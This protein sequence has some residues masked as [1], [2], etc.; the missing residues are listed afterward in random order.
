MGG[1]RNGS[2]GGGGM[3]GGM[4]RRWDSAG[5][6]G[7]ND[8]KRPYQPSTNFNGA[9]NGSVGGYAPKPAYRSYDQ[10]KPPMTS[11]P[12]SYGQQ[13]SYQQKFPG[14]APMQ[15]PPSLSS[16]P[17]PIASAIANYVN[18]PP[19]QSSMPPLPKN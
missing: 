12:P 14:Y 1:M 5:T 4:K 3:Q 19:P 2:S 9:S 7:G 11:A 16:Y 8:Y 18:F 10:N 6:G 13:P 17:S 15:M